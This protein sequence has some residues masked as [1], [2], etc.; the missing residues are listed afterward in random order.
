MSAKFSMALG[1]AEKL[2]R[3]LKLSVPRT[4]AN[5]QAAIRKN[6]NEALQK[7]VAAAPKASGEMA[8]TGRAEYSENG[9]IGYVKFGYGK[10]LRRSRS[11]RANRRKRLANLRRRAGSKSGLG[12]YAPV[13]DRGDPRRHIK[14][15]RFL[16]NTFAQQKP[17]AIK[18]I[19]HALNQSMREI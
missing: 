13:I 14:A 1:G 11:G 6:T 3:E 15:S 9:L 5:V 8:G 17:T 7:A 12:S 16:S 4:R 2:I 19:D 10:L 18:D